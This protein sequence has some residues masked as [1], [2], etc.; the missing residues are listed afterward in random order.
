MARPVT[1]LVIFF[2][3]FNLFAG[4]LMSTGVAGTLGL[5]ANVGE[6]DK[7]DEHEKSAEDV[8]SGNGLGSTLFGMYNILSSQ[9][10]SLFGFIF[11]GLRM[12]RR[13]GVP[14]FITGSENQAGFLPPLF[15]VMMGIGVMS[16]LRGWD[17]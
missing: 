15:S 16:F 6:D 3:A 1:T 14:A 11:P 17:L 13:A 8:A 12:L 5:D 2:L 7:V 4:M 10:G 9:L